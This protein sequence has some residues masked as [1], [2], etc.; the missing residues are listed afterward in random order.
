MHDTVQVARGPRFCSRPDTSG[1]LAT[2]T[3]PAEAGFHLAS[4]PGRS[5]SVVTTLAR[6]IG[7]AEHLLH[8]YGFRLGLRTSTRSGYA[9]PLPKTYL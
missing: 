5:F 3:V 6:T 1:V 8:R 4:L 9:A 2:A 7:Q